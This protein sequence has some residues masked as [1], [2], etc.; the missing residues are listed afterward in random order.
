[1]IKVGRL[2]D[3]RVCSELCPACRGEIVRYLSRLSVVP[4]IQL[5]CGPMCLRMDSPCQ[6]TEAMKV[7]PWTASPANAIV[8]PTCCILRPTDR[9]QLWLSALDYLHAPKPLLEKPERNIGLIIC[10]V[11]G[12]E[13][14]GV[15]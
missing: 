9:F 5:H 10:H 3:H 15:L 13:N 4:R 2:S 8:D 7:Q 12:A 6:L 11:A 14:V 1:M